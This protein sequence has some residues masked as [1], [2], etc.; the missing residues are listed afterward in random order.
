VSNTISNSFYLKSSYTV[1]SHRLIRGNGSWSQGLRSPTTRALNVWVFYLSIF[2][3]PSI[4]P[5]ITSRSSFHSIRHA[6]VYRT[7]RLQDFFRI[8]V[9]L[10]TPMPIPNAFPD[11]AQIFVLRLE[12]TFDQIY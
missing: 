3:S 1:T 10:F 6:Q 4:L 8:S 7:S 5:E 11:Y 12:I 2:S 9:S